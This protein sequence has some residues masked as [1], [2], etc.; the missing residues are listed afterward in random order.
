MTK[1]DKENSSRYFNNSTEGSAQNKLA[2]QNQD[3]RLRN[4]VR[5]KIQNK[6][7]VAI[8]KITKE[9]EMRHSNLT[10]DAQVFNFE[11]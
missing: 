6:V 1:F 9:C 4:E 5:L 2:K 11:Q 10:R 3:Q 7:L 8:A